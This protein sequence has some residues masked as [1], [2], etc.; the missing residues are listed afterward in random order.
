MIAFRLV[1]ADKELGCDKA[2]TGLYADSL[3]NTLKYPAS[4]MEF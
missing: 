1:I 2:Q 4:A 3:P